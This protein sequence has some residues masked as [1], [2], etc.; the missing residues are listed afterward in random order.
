MTLDINPPI[1]IGNK[2]WLSKNSG[3]GTCNFLDRYK[4]FQEYL[5][6]NVIMKYDLKTDTFEWFFEVDGKSAQYLFNEGI[7]FTKEQL[8]ESFRK[9]IEELISED[10]REYLWK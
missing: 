7:A 9:E 6:T 1:K 3:F 5:V 2:V 8:Y 4:Q 10:I